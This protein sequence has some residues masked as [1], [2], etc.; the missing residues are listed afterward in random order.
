M[1]R[2]EHDVIAWAEEQA[3]LLRAGRFG[4]LDIE[5][6]A[7]EI[8]DVGKGEQ[9][10]LASRVSLLLAHLLRWQ[11]QPE[12]RGASWQATIRVQRRALAAHLAS[13]PSLKRMLADANWGTRIWGDAVAKAIDETGLDG[14]P[15]DCP[16]SLENILA[17]DWLPD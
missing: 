12:R 16:W 5:H 13:A 7:D 2:Y 9:R 11:Y 14:F 1:S 17:R 15:E 3:A 8:E 10:A 4:Q 6:L